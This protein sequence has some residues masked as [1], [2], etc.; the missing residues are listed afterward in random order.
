[1]D[2][3]TLVTICRVFFI[4]F[5]IL[6]GVAY[7]LP[8]RP[9]RIWTGVAVCLGAILIGTVFEIWFYNQAPETAYTHAVER[10]EAK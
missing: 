6:L 8:H 9:W 10:G 2:F 7:S 5:L 4:T 3:Q 1:M